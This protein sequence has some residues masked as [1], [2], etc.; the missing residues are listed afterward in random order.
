MT[1]SPSRGSGSPAITECSTPSARPGRC[2]S[3]TWSHTS[4]L[5]PQPP[6]T[7][8][9]RPSTTRK[10]PTGRPR[11]SGAIPSYLIEAVAEHVALAVLE[12][13]GVYC[14]DVRIHKPQAPLHVEFKD[15][16]VAIRR[17]IRTGGLWAD[18][19]I[20]SSAG[21]PDDPLDLVAQAPVHDQFDERPVRAVP[22]LLA[23][24]GNIGDV[25][26]DAACSR[27]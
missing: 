26:A 15:V 1:G 20:G 10:S 4:R 19:R 18:K 25:E 8:S 6:G 27:R 11:C 12:M 16:T 5:A 7:T 22:V 24:G 23:L 21:M 17:D 3:P 9:P 13:E 2:S 14:V